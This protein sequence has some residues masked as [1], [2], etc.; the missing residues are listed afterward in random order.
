[1]NRLMKRA[2]PIAAILLSLLLISAFSIYETGDSV[3]WLNQHVVTLE[4]CEAGQGFSDLAPLSAAIGDARIVG[5]GESTH[6]TR[7]H[8]QM[9]HR[10]VEY[11]VEELG[12]TWFM[13]E[14]ST[15]EAHLLD[16]YVLGAEGDPE[17]LIRGMYFWTWTTE[18][19]LAMVEWMRAYNARSD[20]KVHF[21][22]FD[23]Q[24]PN[25][26][27]AQAIRF[28]REVE[29]PLTDRAIEVYSKAIVAEDDTTFATATYAVAA[30]AAR[31]K[32]I[33]FSAWIQ[34]EDIHN[35]YAGLWCRIDGREGTPFAFDNMV[36]R[37][38]SGTTEW[39]ECAIELPVDEEADHIVFGFLLTGQGNAWFDAA[40]LTVD[41]VPLDTSK[42]DLEF[43]G[44]G[45]A[46]AHT[47]LG[48]YSSQMDQS[49]AYE[50]AQSLRLTGVERI[51]NTPLV[52]DVLP[53]AET[54][55][56]DM[57]AAREVWLSLH[58]AEEVERA[59][60]NA[61]IV[62][63][64]L[65]MKANSIEGSRDAAMADNVAWLAEQFPDE[66]LVLWAH[67][68]H[69]S[70]APGMMGAHLADRFGDG[71]LPIGFATASGRYYAIGDQGQRLHDLQQPPT[72]SFE[73]TFAAATAPTFA[74][75]LRQ[76]ES[77]VAGS[78]WL[79]ETR[80][81]RLVGSLAMDEQFFPTP[82]RD[83]YDLIVFIEETTPARQL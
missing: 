78:A 41:G 79:T 82:L 38:L 46:G 80:P 58:S 44:T 36:D 6:G 63:Q 65:R 60:L 2:V 1:M 57:G 27:A 37:G 74:L 53:E 76:V 12:F 11:L 61:R 72:E 23:M 81:F 21:T 7:E 55:L 71:Y 10:L 39:T 22:G 30:D 25:V 9:K 83:Y 17:Q 43:E 62:V 69:I 13:I 75:D 40:N 19:V 26:A 18:E 67:N 16:A 8:F 56:A 20:V 73:A 24:T 42:L 54:I 49:A 32:T 28:L 5:L 66:R 50:G 52:S 45:I 70:R 34:T 14:A 48:S 29:S 47:N 68:A 35:G 33:R 51:S 64:Y 3:S 77:E 31:G 4:G 59:L 15:P